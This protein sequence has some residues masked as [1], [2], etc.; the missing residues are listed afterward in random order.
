MRSCDDL[1]VEEYE[2]DDFAEL[3]KDEELLRWMAPS[4]MLGYSDFGGISG[5]MHP[6]RLTE[7]LYDHDPDPDPSGSAGMLAMLLKQRA[8]ELPKDIVEVLIKF[9]LE[10]DGDP[11]ALVAAIIAYPHLLFEFPELNNPDRYVGMQGTPSCSKPQM[12]SPN[13]STPNL[14][15]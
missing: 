7:L 11:Y 15:S 1:A 10:N 9:L 14:L 13:A 8:T 2:E 4:I 6:D 12:N 3:E 5:P